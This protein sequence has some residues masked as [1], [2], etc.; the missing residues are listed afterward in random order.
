[1]FKL[2]KT[3]NKKS[4][5]KSHTI[6]YVAYIII[7]Y[8]NL[9]LNFLTFQPLLTSL[10][11]NIQTTEVS[12]SFFPNEIGCFIWKELEE[13]TAELEQKKVIFYMNNLEGNSSS[14]YYIINRLRHLFPEYSIINID[15]PG[16][17]LSNILNC[18][19]KNINLLISQAITFYLKTNHV[20]EYGFITENE[21]CFLISK[22]LT[23]IEEIP[24][25]VIALN[26]VNNLFERMIYKYSIFSFPLFL[27]YC[28]TNSMVDNI[29]FFVE[30]KNAYDLT[31][32]LFISNSERNDTNRLYIK[33]DKINPSR[34]TRLHIEGFGATSLIIDKNFQLLESKLNFILRN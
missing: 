30:K 32:F 2:F 4:L 11:D 21:A 29:S 22:I 17:G 19:L 13:N 25:F 9:V 18:S 33:L 16:Y 27:P 6:F 26:P 7:L 15:Y 14:R 23:M 31:R 8:Y 12:V 34:K 20:Q 28:F 24:K 5:S 10:H 1:M 3:N